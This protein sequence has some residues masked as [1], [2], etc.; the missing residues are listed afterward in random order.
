MHK[1]GN[2][3]PVW[4]GIISCT[5]YSGAA[6]VIHRPPGPA[7]R[8]DQLAADRPGF[9]RGQEHCEVRNLGTVHHA[10]DGVAAWGVRGKVTPLRLFWGNAQLSGT[11]GQQAWGALS[12]SSAGV[13]AVDRNPI[14]AQLHRQGLGEV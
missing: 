2:P 14:A 5:Q 12:A 7:S 4:R 1:A 11:G 9:V 10:T 3:P 8:H 6:L 13:D